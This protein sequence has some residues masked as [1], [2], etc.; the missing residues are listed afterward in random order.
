MLGKDVVGPGA[1]TA[2]RSI[3][4]NTTI[5]NLG[6]AYLLQ[7]TIILHFAVRRRKDS[8]TKIIVE[9]VI[10]AIVLDAGNDVT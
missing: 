7:K 1:G 5:Q 8:S 9:V 4:H 2:E 10:Q 3:A 6:S